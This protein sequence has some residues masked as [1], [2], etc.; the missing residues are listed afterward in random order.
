MYCTKCGIQLDEKAKFCSEC[1]AS[2]ATGNSWSASA[3]A[4]RNV[5]LSRPIYDKK[6]AG[7]CAGFA[8]YFDVD[9]TV[10]RVL[11]ILFAI[12]PVP[13]TSILAYFIAWIVMPRDPLALP[14]PAI[15]RSQPV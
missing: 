1:G 3:Q 10:V 7:V 9:V 12:F 2:T 5:R 15:A 8:R 11:W 14:E 6:I 13:F 4:L